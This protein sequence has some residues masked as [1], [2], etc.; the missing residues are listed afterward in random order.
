MAKPV[1]EKIGKQIKTIEEQTGL[2]KGLPEALVEINK[3]MIE[4][5]KE[6][7]RLRG[8]EKEETHYVN[9]DRGIH[10]DVIKEFPKVSV[11]HLLEK[12]EQWLEALPA[13]SKE[14]HKLA[15]RAAKISRKGMRENQLRKKKSMCLIGGMPLAHI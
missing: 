1:T 4:Y 7:E 5:E 6:G 3:P 2:L 9:L 15:P 10:Y 13:V 12:P 8:I 11:L 14:I